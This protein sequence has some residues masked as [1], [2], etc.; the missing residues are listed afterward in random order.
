M[1]KESQLPNLIRLGLIIISWTTIFF[2]PKKAIRRF[3]PAATFS[4]LF[5]LILSVL[6][7]PY[8]LWRV[9][10]GFRRKIF[11]DFSFIFGPYFVGTI[12][13]FHLSYGRFWLYSLLNLFM[14]ALLSYPL[15]WLFQ[16]FK[17]LKL[18]NFK[19]KYIFFTIYSFAFALYGYQLFIT[20]DK[21]TDK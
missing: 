13:I 4:S 19:P 11:N 6:S 10:G 14:D 18:V 12:W 5:I 20:T 17:L 15:I 2:I 1:R 7:I 3:T 16:K 9:R 8:K 21:S